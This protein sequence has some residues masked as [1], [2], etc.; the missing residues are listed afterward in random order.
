MT[1]WDC[2][3]KDTQEYY[4]RNNEQYACDYICWNSPEI[5]GKHNLIYTV[6]KITDMQNGYCDILYYTG[7]RN[8]THTAYNVPVSQLEIIK[9]NN[10]D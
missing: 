6:I 5:K 2:N 9:E 7:V 1:D 4:D 8:D 10:N 3:P